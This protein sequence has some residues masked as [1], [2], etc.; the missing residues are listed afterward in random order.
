MDSQLSLYLRL[1]LNGKPVG[2]YGPFRS[3]DAA[4]DALGELVEELGRDGGVVTS[5]LVEESER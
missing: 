3:V 5:E 1:F 2:E 4:T